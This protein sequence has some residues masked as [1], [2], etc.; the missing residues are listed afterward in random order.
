[1]KRLFTLMAVSIIVISGFASTNSKI[2]GVVVYQHGAKISREATVK[3]VSGTNEIIISDL[4]TGIDANSLQVKVYGSAVL[5]SATSGIRTLENKEIP[6]RT[7]MLED[8]LKL[9]VTEINW[10]NSERNVYEGEEKLIE[11]NKNLRS[12]KDGVSVEEI[13][14]LSEFYRNRLLDIRKQIHKIEEK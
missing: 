11:E 3:L 12:E 13:I 8:S 10:L 9:I 14:R 7:K 6:K 2:T 4:T 5:L 1:M